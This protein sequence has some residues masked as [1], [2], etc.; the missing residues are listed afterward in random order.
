M[1]SN[2]NYSNNYIRFSRAVAHPE[3]K[4]VWVPE[5]GTMLEEHDV[6]VIILDR[7]AGVQP[8]KYRR[9]ALLSSIKN[10]PVTFV[11]FGETKPGNNYSVGVKY[12]LTARVDL[13]TTEGFMNYVD[14]PNHPQNTCEG[15]SGGP[16]LYNDPTDGLEVVGTVS[17]GDKY[18]RQ[19][20]YNMR[21][22]QN[23][24]WISEMV[25]KYDS[26][27]G[28]CGD[29]ACSPDENCQTCPQDCGICPPDCGDGKCETSKGENC[30]NCSKDCGS[31]NKYCGDGKC[32]A[33]KG[34]NCQTCQKDCGECLPVCGDGKCETDRGEACETCPKDC[35]PCIDGDIQRDG[36][37]AWTEEGTQDE[38]TGGG[39]SYA[40]APGTMAGSSLLLVI[41][42]LFLL[43]W[44]KK[45][46]NPGR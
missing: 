12:S 27:Q 14:D 25:A 33:S 8:M 4:S 37:D 10:Q 46:P 21:V 41:G 19:M 17:S 11:G 32:D 9:T 16:A 28:R 7:A 5:V 40:A 2:I 20:G 43:F 18:C 6:G 30:Q 45:R 22:D 13:I 24:T 31:C 36:G 1:G 3:Y 34:G 44:R 39:C 23:A 42:L 35:G 15:D 26:I 29:G 38:S